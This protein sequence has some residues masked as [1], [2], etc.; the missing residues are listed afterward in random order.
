LWRQE[1]EV[2]VEVER[3][4]DSH[5]LNLSLNLN[6]PPTLEDFFSFRPKNI[7]LK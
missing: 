7:C 6:L 5:L 2:E 1:V 4:F 3:R